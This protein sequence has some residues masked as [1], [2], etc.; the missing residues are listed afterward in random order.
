MRSSTKV[1]C[2]KI[3]DQSI[4]DRW[5]L[6]R[7]PVRTLPIPHRYFHAMAGQQAFPRQDGHASNRWA[8]FEWTPFCLWVKRRDSRCMRCFSDQYAAWTRERMSVSGYAPLQQLV[9]PLVLRWSVGWDRF[10]LLSLCGRDHWS[11]PHGV[12][13]GVL[14][15]SP[16]HHVHALH[17]PRVR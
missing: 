7:I 14:L 11:G 13:L 9:R 8:P 2:D 3:S 17:C 15:V 12:A 5:T 16:Q 6:H 4:L 10:L 1:Y